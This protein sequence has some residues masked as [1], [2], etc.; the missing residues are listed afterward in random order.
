[1]VRIAVIDYNKCK[2]TKC[3]FECG[4]SCPSNRQGKECITRVDIV[5]DIED[6][7]KKTKKKT[8]IQASLCIGCNLCIKAC[9][10]EAISI[11]NLPEELKIDKL[12]YS[13]GENSFRIY[14]YPSIKKGQCVGILGANGLGKSTILKILVDPTLTVNNKMFVGDE[15]YKYMCSL[16]EG[17]IVV[18]YKPQEISLFSSKQDTVRDFVT[19]SNSSNL[20]S[21]K[22]IKDFQLEHLLDRKMSQLSG[23]ELQRLLISL[24][25]VK[26]ANSYIFDEPSAFLDIKQR[27]NASNLITE[28]CTENTY[29]V[30]VEHD[31]CILDYIC[32]YVSCL[33]GEA[34]GFGVVTGTYG[35]RNGINSYLDG[36]FKNEN[37]QI[38][39]EPVYFNKYIIDNAQ[40]NNS[41]VYKYESFEIKYDNFNLFANGGNINLCEI[42]LLVGE[43][44]TGKTSFIQNL[45][46]DGN[47]VSSIK[48]Q[49]PYI[50]SI[51]T[52]KTITVAEYLE[53]Q[54]N[55]SLGDA[56]F[57]SSVIKSLGVD[58]LFDMEV[59]TLSGGQMQ[60][61]SIVICLGK[62]ANVYLLDE[63]SAFI[64]VED[65]CKLAKIIKQFAYDYKK[66]IFI[67]E[68]DITLATNIA[69]KVIVFE[70]APGISCTASEPCNL[71]TGINKFL[72]NLNITMRKDLTTGRPGI[73]KPN[74]Q[75]DMLQRQNNTYFIVE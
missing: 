10:F 16:N 70:G 9:P 4:K 64:D 48:V 38:R 74:S 31:L 45:S 33:Y 2:P 20:L 14:K 17:K 43:N 71:S 8:V 5:P 46:K 22:Y 7:V 21:S 39:D 23:G 1:M 65:R 49:N 3:N 62:K 59:L 69:D 60:K 52:D 30:C 34:N 24:T 67:I 50:K 28:K 72:R 12:L 51:K 56:R 35:V 75:K 54:I 18:S 11:I 26:E 37:L 36:Y 42:V 63:P 57:M 27:I 15:M 19:I 68:H 40:Q 32:D 58:K 13:Y 29:L 6:I 47:L 41:C 66:T 61:L 44:G 55:S 73:N 25:C 53:N